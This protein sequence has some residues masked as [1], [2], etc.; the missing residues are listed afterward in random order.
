MT[1]K[2]IN[3]V[4]LSEYNTVFCD[5][6]QAVKWAYQNGLP[7]TAVIKSSSPAVLW[8]ERKNIHNV[9]KRWSVKELK[10]F[11]NIYYYNNDYSF[12]RFSFFFE[13]IYF[14]KMFICC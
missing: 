13:F 4:N 5:S 6:L 10:E 1:L 12:L 2:N 9:E 3:K 8:S 14:I 7:K 11:Q